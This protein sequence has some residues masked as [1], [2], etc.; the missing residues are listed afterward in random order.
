MSE[1]GFISGVI[2]WTCSLSSWHRDVA[3]TLEQWKNNIHQ[4]MAAISLHIFHKMIE[5]FL[6]GSKFSKFR[7]ADIGILFQIYIT[8]R[9]KLCNKKINFIKKRI[10]IK[11]HSAH[12]KR[13]MRK[14]TN[15]LSVD[16]KA[17]FDS[18]N[19]RCLYAA[20]SEF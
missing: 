2:S 11:V 9:V 7:K 10:G 6:T 12:K 1:Y 3:L 4:V 13:E 17:A 14:A 15:H 8:P 16:F 19:R 18:S 20:N 5:N